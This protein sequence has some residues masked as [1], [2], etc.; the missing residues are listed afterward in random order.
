M[1]KRTLN[2]FWNT[3]VSVMDVIVEILS[4]LVLITLWV[5]NYYFQHQSLAI[6]PEG[7]D[8]FQNPNETRCVASFRWS[9]FTFRPAF[10]FT[11]YAALLSAV[12]AMEEVRSFLFIS[13]RS[14]V[15]RSSKHPLPH[16]RACSSTESSTSR[17]SWCS[18]ASF[19]TSSVI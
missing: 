2:T 4:L 18:S 15:H 19:C 5:E 12:H 10:A 6:V 9:A 14:R 8:F 7:Y 13:S 11:H 16:R 1:E 3:N 17:C